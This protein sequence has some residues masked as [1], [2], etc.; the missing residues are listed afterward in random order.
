MEFLR[1]GR[2]R[3]LK[4]N[5]GQGVPF[6]TYPMLEACGMVIHGFST[7]IGGV[8]QGYFSSMNLGFGRGDAEENVRENF[9][10]I[11]DSIGFS[12]EIW[13]CPSRRTLQMYR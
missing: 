1:T 2:N 4:V 5:H 13:C 12:A 7:R 10:R 9:R 6:L 8:S 11:A 3:I